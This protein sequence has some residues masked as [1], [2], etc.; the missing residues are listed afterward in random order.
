MSPLDSKTQETEL[1][2]EKLDAISNCE[3]N[4][5]NY[6]MEQREMEKRIQSSQE[7]ETKNLQGNQRR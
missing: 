3:R 4:R 1:W 2:R 5:E 7:T 6:L